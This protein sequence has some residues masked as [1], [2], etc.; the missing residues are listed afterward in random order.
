VATL[1]LHR[2]NARP[3][4]QVWDGMHKQTAR[5]FMN[6]LRFSTTLFIATISLPACDDHEVT[7]YGDLSVRSAPWAKVICTLGTSDR[8]Y[9][10]TAASP[11]LLHPVVSRCELQRLADTGILAPT[12]EGWFYAC[13]PGGKPDTFQ[14][15]LCFY[16]SNTSVVC[17]GGS[18]DW[19]TKVKPSCAPTTFT[20]PA[21]VAAGCSLDLNPGPHEYDSVMIDPNGPTWLARAVDDSDAVMVSQECA[22]NGGTSAAHPLSCSWDVGKPCCSC[23]ENGTLSC[24]AFD[25]PFECPVG[26]NTTT[27]A[28]EQPEGESTDTTDGGETVSCCVCNPNESEA[29]CHDVPGDVCPI[30]WDYGPLVCTP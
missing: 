29:E 5:G 7:E 21:W 13:D 28:C 22:V 1:G 26:T 14:D 8:C 30:G 12:T 25:S 11:E 20:H 6:S 4:V 15:V 16:D 9:A 17:Y 3:V 23:D 19:Y 27:M 18:G 24:V 10:K 2:R